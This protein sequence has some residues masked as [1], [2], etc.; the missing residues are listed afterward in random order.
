MTKAHK[1]PT[2]TNNKYKT[3]QH[4]YLRMVSLCNDNHQTGVF[5]L[6]YRIATFPK[7]LCYRGHKDADIIFEW[8]ESSQTEDGQSNWQ[9]T[10]PI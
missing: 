5:K 2:P 4:K 3:W 6:V 1:K 7:Q 9:Q 10:L 8:A